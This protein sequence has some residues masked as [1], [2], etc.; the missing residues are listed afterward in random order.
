ME[1]RL[2][3]AELDKGTED[4]STRLEGRMGRRRGRGG[5]EEEEEME[6]KKQERTKE[7]KG[8][9]EWVS[10]GEERRR[11]GKQGIDSKDQG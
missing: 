6:R 9:H 3:G 7:A 4:G 8:R 10:R 2:N 11:R 5:R 1:S